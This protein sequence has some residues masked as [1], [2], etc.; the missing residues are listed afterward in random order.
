MDKS[1]Q[2]LLERIQ[3]Q[4]RVG[5]LADLSQAMTPCREPSSLST[6]DGDFASIIQC[7]CLNA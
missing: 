2:P 1:P 3:D 7:R 6:I 5:R 4:R